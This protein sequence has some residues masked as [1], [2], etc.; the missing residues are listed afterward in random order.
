MRALSSDLGPLRAPCPLRCVAWLDP[1]LSVL[2]FFPRVPER[3][4]LFLP[5]GTAPSSPDR[6]RSCH[7]RVAIGRLDPPS[8]LCGCQ[9]EPSPLFSPYGLAPATPELAGHHALPRCLPSLM[10]ACCL[11]LLTGRRCQSP[12]AMATTIASWTRA[13]PPSVG[14]RASCPRRAPSQR[15]RAVSR[16]C[17]EPVC[18]MCYALHR[19]WPSSTPHLSH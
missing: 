8:T 18:S 13:S 15:N 3:F 5:H 19:R 6:R 1:S 10:S 4:S 14:A 2:P 16:L 11:L 7:C 9:P 12:T 17:S